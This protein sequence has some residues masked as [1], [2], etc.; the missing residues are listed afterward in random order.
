MKHRFLVLASVVA[1]VA[2][3]PAPVPVGARDASGIP[4]ATPQAPAAPETHRACEAVEALGL[5]ACHVD[6]ETVFAIT[7]MGCSEDD[8]I[9]YTV[10][11]T[12]VRGRRLRVC[13]G[14]VF[15]GCT[16]RGPA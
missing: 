9:A 13:C 5:A 2:C 6:D 7:W 14:F 1:F 12:N 15:K 4:P 11:A 10:S 16:V 8:G 3:D